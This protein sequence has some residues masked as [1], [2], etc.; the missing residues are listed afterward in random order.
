MNTKDP[1]MLEWQREANPKAPVHDIEILRARLQEA[2][3]T[4]R[5]IRLGEVDALIVEGPDGPRTYTLVTA[6]QSYRMLV[7]QMRDAALTLSMDG[8]ILYSNSRL[9]DPLGME[10][11]SVAGRPLLDLAVPDD[12]YAL[13]EVLWRAREENIAA[14][15]RLMRTDGSAVPFH[16][17]LSPLRA[18]SFSGICAVAVNLT[19]QKAREQAMV[20]E[21]LTRAIVEH[22]ATAILVCAG[23]GI[24]MRA[25]RR[26]NDLFGEDVVGRSFDEVCPAGVGFAELCRSGEQLLAER[27]LCFLHGDGGQRI[28][29]VSARPIRAGTYSDDLRWV[30][31]FVDIT[32]RHEAEARL[33]AAKDAADAASRAKGDFMAMMSHELRTPLN[34][35]IGYAQLLELGVPAGIPEHAMRHAERIRLSAHHL[36]QLIDEILTFS[37]LEA[38][39][40][41]VEIGTLDVPEIVREVTAIMEPLVQGKG[42]DF[43]A[44]VDTREERIETDPRKVRQILLNLLGNAVKFTENGSIALRVCPAR[45]GIRF[46]VADTGIG[47]SPEEQA[48][49][50]EPFW[51]ADATRTRKTGGSGLGLVITQRLVDLLGGRIHCQSALGQGAVFAVELPA[52]LESPPS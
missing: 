39:R 19:E 7:E 20:D 30:V 35:I 28:L 16:I 4:L 14:E 32:E 11:R 25:N 43:I 26:A 48:R 27:E 2:E 29:L 18:G 49:M 36:K 9:S 37:R 13:R 46:E 22:A 40:E 15:L 10:Y 38:G 47:I 33:L 3:E 5:A 21:R 1:A 31:T 24:V 42:L 12:R 6:D 8:V 51:Q 44:E 52:R 45:Q 17:S 34:A 50:F 41:P 23:N